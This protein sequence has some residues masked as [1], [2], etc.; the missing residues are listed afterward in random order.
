MER[1]TVICDWSDHD[2][3]DADEI[4]VLADSRGEAISKARAKWA[5]T[6]G[7]KWPEC[8]LDRVYIPPECGTSNEHFARIADRFLRPPPRN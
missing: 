8:T 3:F 4:V 7:A 1:Y 2:V 5:I 6:K